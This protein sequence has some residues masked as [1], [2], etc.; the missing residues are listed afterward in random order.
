MFCRTTA[1]GL[2]RVTFQRHTFGGSPLSPVEAWENYLRWRARPGIDFFDEP[3]GIE[4][5]IADW[6]SKGLATPRTWTDLYL[7]AFAVTDNLR[8][9]AFDRDFEKFPGLDL[10]HLEL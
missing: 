5:L 10:L 3:V 6:C 4:N 8:F 2:V 9:V 7:A 1:L